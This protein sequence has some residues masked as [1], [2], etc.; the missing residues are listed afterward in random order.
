MSWM[1]R[2]AVVHSIREWPGGIG[3]RVP[4]SVSP[5]WQGSEPSSSAPP[6]WPGSRLSWGFQCAWSEIVQRPSLLEFLELGADSGTVPEHRE[7]LRAAWVYFLSS[8]YSHIRESIS[9]DLQMDRQTWDAA[10]V[11]FHFSLPDMVLLK[12]HWAALAKLKGIIREAGIGTEAGHCVILG[13]AEIEAVATAVLGGDGSEYLRT[14]LVKVGEGA[15]SLLEPSWE[16]QLYSRSR[17]PYNVTV[18]P[19][20]VGDKELLARDIQ[21]RLQNI[22]S[23]AIVATGPTAQPCA[24]ALRNALD[25]NTPSAVPGGPRVLRVLPAG[26]TY[27]A[28]VEGLLVRR[29]AWGTTERPLP[30][31]RDSNIPCL[32]TR[33]SEP[34]NNLDVSR[35]MYTMTNTIVRFEVETVRPERPN[36]TQLQFDIFFTFDTRRAPG[37]VSTKAGERPSG[38]T[39]LCSV[40]SSIEGE[41]FEAMP[42]KDKWYTLSSRTVYIVRFSLRL[43]AM[44]PS[45]QGPQFQL[46]VRDGASHEETRRETE[47]TWHAEPPHTIWPPGMVARQMDRRRA[48]PPEAGD[49]PPQL[50]PRKQRDQEAPTGSVE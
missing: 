14:L 50:P 17:K 24:D 27:T 20:A 35:L 28:A 44:E 7:E 22:S 25:S 36:L 1:T 16:G 41:S 48:P 13:L 37:W 18:L 31:F 43:L 45:K 8:L 6:E 21:P 47:V 10:A 5:Q 49:C 12:P 38:L 11:E 15:V 32:F 3:P 30:V 34:S 33:L 19:G 23:I 42:V 29:Q 4:T 2:D 26:E 9:K 46:F 40:R 39:R